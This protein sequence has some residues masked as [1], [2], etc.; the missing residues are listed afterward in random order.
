MSSRFLSVP[1]QLSL[2][3]CTHGGMSWLVQETGNSPHE[4]WTNQPCDLALLC[5]FSVLGSL[6][7]KGQRSQKASQAH[8]SRYWLN[9]W[10]KTPAYSTMAE[11]PTGRIG[12]H[13]PQPREWI[14][15][16]TPGNLTFEKLDS[17][18]RY[19]EIRESAFF[20]FHGYF[21]SKNKT[22]EIS[23]SQASE[24]GSLWRVYSH[25]DWGRG[26]QSL[27]VWS[28]EPTG[29]TENWLHKLF[30]C[31]GTCSSPPQKL[32]VLKNTK[33]HS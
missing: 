33:K 4:L 24:R 7:G 2:S 6:A 28:A 26:C 13:S 29:Q 31:H 19:G 17:L 23:N 30:K 1:G 10:I 18:F 14:Q 22:T 15:I 9:N 12:P 21:L 16:L 27:T 20:L 32:N 8:I 3:H 25:I 5:L 11:M